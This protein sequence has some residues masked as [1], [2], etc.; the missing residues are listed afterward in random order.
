LNRKAAKAECWTYYTRQTPPLFIV[1]A[2]GIAAV[3][4]WR[5]RFL[6]E[7]MRFNPQVAIGNK[8]ILGDVY[9]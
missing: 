3:A 7:Q 9:R 5:V 1:P 8:R 6:I 2:Y 4:F